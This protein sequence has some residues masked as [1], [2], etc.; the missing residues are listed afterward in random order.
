M[1]EE[2]LNEHS[3]EVDP[4]LPSPPLEGV[5]LPPITPK[6]EK[7]KFI[8]LRSL[9]VTQDASIIIGKGRSSLTVS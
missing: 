2:G 4:P 6:D 3:M 5:T 9:I 8:S 1:E 7:E